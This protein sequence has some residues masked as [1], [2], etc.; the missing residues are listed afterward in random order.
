M[1]TNQNPDPTYGKDLTPKKVIFQGYIQFGN[2]I[3]VHVCSFQE[4]ATAYTTKGLVEA[5]IDFFGVQPI[6]S[7][8]TDAFE[9]YM[10]NPKILSV[11]SQVFCNGVQQ[12]PVLIESNGA[13]YP[14]CSA[15]FSIENP[16]WDT[17]VDCY[18]DT[19][20]I[21]F[22]FRKGKWNIRHTDKQGGGTMTIPTP[23]YPKTRQQMLDLVEIIRAM[24]TEC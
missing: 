7:D 13:R 5:V 16:L 9:A 1:N 6:T 20:S 19:W 4:L 21:N 24:K 12:S 22:A 11:K 10:I 2:R 15:S 8:I 23:V 14:S 18:T 3:S 17:A